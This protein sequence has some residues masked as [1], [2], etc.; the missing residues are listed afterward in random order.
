M[1]NSKPPPPTLTHATMPWTGGDAY[2]HGDY[3]WNDRRVA[4]VKIR[5]YWHWNNSALYSRSPDIRPPKS[6]ETR[7]VCHF[8]VAAPPPCRDVLMSTK[9]DPRAVADNAL[10]GLPLLASSL[11]WW[12]LWLFRRASLFLLASRCLRCLTYSFILDVLLRLACGSGGSFVLHLSL[13]GSLSW[14]NEP[15][16]ATRSSAIFV[17]CLCDYCSFLQVCKCDW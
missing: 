2:T 3:L 5:Q 13:S 6:H 12:G 7:P 11:E 10:G 17:F 14:P 8:T 15:T 1:C 4:A 9:R 16:E